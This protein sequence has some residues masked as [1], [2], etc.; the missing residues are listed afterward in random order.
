MTAPTILPL[1]DEGLGNQ[2]YLVDLGEGR[3]LA[4]DPTLDLRSLDAAAAAHGLTVAFA[5]ETHLHAD[6]L[7][8]A[9]RLARRDGARVISS[10]DGGRR[11]DA[12]GLADGDEVD[13][14]GLTLR[15]WATPGHTD[16][17]MAY[18]LTD[19]DEPW[20]VFTGGSLI[21]G[22]AA[23][24]DLLGAEHT[25]ELARAQ[26]RSLRRLAEL[27]D[28]TLVFPTHGAGSFCAAPPG[29]DRTST[30]GRGEG[31][32]PADAHRRRGRVRGGPGLGPGHATRRTSPVWPT[33]TGRARRPGPRRARPAGTSARFWPAAARCAGRRRATRRPTTRPATSRVRWP[34][35]CGESFA[36]WLGWLVP[37]PSTPLVIVRDPD[38]DP[39]EIVW[40][41]RKVGYFG[42]VGE[43]AGGVAAWAAGGEPHGPTPIGR[44][45][46]PS[47]RP[48]WST[49]GSAR[50]SPPGTCPAP[51][52]S[53]SAPSARPRCR[54]GRS[55]RCAG[56]ANAR[57]PRPASW[58]D[59]GRS[60][61]PI[62]AGGPGDWARATG[63]TVEVGT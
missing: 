10:A 55:S 29:A 57:Q 47:T 30:I 43:L 44:P 6:F 4:V 52:T 60:D 62:M 19:G 11:F 46:G 20:A 16:E 22:A 1:L 32:Q 34:S 49:C 21:V 50:S 12:P 13:L 61:V 26:F 7:S 54:T 3:A 17:H 15:G 59:A 35:H 14:G 25:D 2:A 33:R 9:A 27:P 24:T 8:G 31:H 53:S 45:R 42:I 48:P 40:Q 63:G 37:D 41:A 5:A 23:R 39:D 38:Q 36:T 58:N 18:L 56:T 51:S 28:D